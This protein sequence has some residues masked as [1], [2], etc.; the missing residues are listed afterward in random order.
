MAETTFSRGALVALPLNDKNPI[1]REPDPWVELLARLG[2]V[3]LKLQTIAWQMRLEGM[4][5]YA[6]ADL[7]LDCLRRTGD[8]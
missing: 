2:Q 1:K 6:F 5:P 7:V 8:A 4:D 3:S